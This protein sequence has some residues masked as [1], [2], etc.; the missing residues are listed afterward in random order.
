MKPF[1]IDPSA[2]VADQSKK[3]LFTLRVITIA[4]II[5]PLLMTG[6]FVMLRSMQA[7]PPAAAADLVQPPGNPLEGFLISKIM[8]G[9]AFS[10]LAA[11]L[12]L[13]SLLF[14]GPMP[15]NPA[16]QPYDKSGRSSSDATNPSE[17]LISRYQA[18]SIVTGAPRGR[19]QSVC[20]RLPGRRPARKPRGRRLPA[21]CPDHPHAH[22]GPIRGLAREGCRR[23]SAVGTPARS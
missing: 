1:P 14:D 7:K 13:P 2:S 6:V 11:A 22:R 5:G 4:L 20:G 9:I 3:A 21:G 10:A 15:R 19:C 17:S 8:L 23:M 18:R 12:V 16:S